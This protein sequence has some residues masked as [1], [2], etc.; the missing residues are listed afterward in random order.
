MNEVAG[1]DC[2]TDGNALSGC[3][4]A[5]RHAPPNSAGGST[6]E[7]LGSAADWPPSLR[8]PPMRLPVP[9]HHAQRASLPQR[10]RATETAAAAAA[11]SATRLT[12]TGYMT[13]GQGARRWR[14]H[15]RRPLG[16]QGGPTAAA[17]NGNGR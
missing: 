7:R 15:Q 4:Q 5:P 3:E 16:L 2:A 17:A 10:L 14:S 12:S 8:F 9:Q 11:A 13:T 1:R 6:A